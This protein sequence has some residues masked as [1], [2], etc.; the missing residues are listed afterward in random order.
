MLFGITDIEFNLETGVADP[1]G[2]LRF[3][4][5]VCAE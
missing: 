3:H 2:S 4:V 1:M 5:Q